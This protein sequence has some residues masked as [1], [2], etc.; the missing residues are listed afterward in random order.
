MEYRHADRLNHFTTG[1]FAAMDEKKQALMRSGRKVYNLSVGTPDFKPSKHVMEAVAEAALIPENYRYTLVDSGE[2]L[3]SVVRYY[4][5][6]YGVDVSADE[7]H[8][9]RGTQ[10]GM[11]HMGLALCNPGDVVMLPDPGYP[12]YEAGTFLAGAE[13]YYYPLLKENEFLPVLSDI[14][15]E[16]LRKARFLVVS[17]PSNPVGAAAPRSMYEELIEYAKKYD[18]LIVNDNA[19]SDIIFDGREGFSFLSIP[20]AKDVG[21]EFFSLSKSFN[22]TGL[23][24]SFL[25][26]NKSV[27][28]AL[29]LLRTQYDFG[30][31]WPA[32]KA[33]MAALDGPMDD[34]IRQCGQYQARRD[35]LCGSLR[36]IGWNA[37]DSQG[38]M[39]TWIPVPEGYT[40]AS[41]VETLMETC[42]VV[43]TPGR[44]FGPA[45]EGY[46]RFALVYP[47]EVLR[48]IAGV[49]G[50][51]F[52]M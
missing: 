8:G 6:R 16:V 31:S 11:G 2:M 27:V 30:I 17:Y 39:F 25:I 1:I 51:N 18:F 32:Q 40:S 5:R 4:K 41:C 33:V 22:L 24:L 12:I 49:I 28:D 43:G 20:G 23:R 50:E 9:V 13:P 29:K 35:A 14:P 19:Y 38:T 36:K 46:I 10:E 44:A 45:G 47:A 42:G 34:V 48:E 26:G 21:V 7:I 37:W 15:E 3:D 52:P